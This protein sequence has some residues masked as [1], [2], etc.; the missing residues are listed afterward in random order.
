MRVDVWVF[1]FSKLVNVT[2]CVVCSLFAV[3]LSCVWF[4]VV[5]LLRCMLSLG[6]VYCFL[7]APV[8]L[9]HR[10]LFV[11]YSFACLCILCACF[12]FLVVFQCFRSVFKFSWDFPPMCW[13]KLVVRLNVVSSR[14]LGPA[15]IE[16]QLGLSFLI[17][18][19]SALLFAGVALVQALARPQVEAQV[20]HAVCSTLWLHFVCAIYLYI[21][22][23][24]RSKRRFSWVG[25]GREA[26]AT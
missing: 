7:S 21:R 5:C 26:C 3:C 9:A 17:Q 4:Q 14:V 11:A 22:L 13:F 12:G 15:S 2:L 25:F 1:S 16:L 23:H 6:F 8:R 10:W 19:A 18:F 24:I 20:A